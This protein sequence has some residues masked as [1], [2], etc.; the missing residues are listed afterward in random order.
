MKNVHQVSLTESSACAWQMIMENWLNM[1]IKHGKM[2]KHGLYILS[3]MVEETWST[4][5]NMLK[6]G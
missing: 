3:D 4:C 6:Y 1:V 5:I 2:V